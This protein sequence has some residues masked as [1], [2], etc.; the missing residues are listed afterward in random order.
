VPR[1]QQAQT[2]DFVRSVK[3]TQDAVKQL[4]IQAGATVKKTI[5]QVTAS[6]NANPYFW[7]GDTTGWIGNNG[8]LSISS[9]PPT[10]T[11]FPYAGFFTI[12]NAGV[13]AAMEE[14]QLP[15]F[16]VPGQ[17]YTVAAYVNPS[18]NT[19]TL[20]LAWTDGTGTL[21]S[22]SSAT[23][24]VAP[25]TWTLVS[26]TFT[27]PTS[28]VFGY[29]RVAPADVVGNTVYATAITTQLSTQ[30]FMSSTVDT[31][32]AVTLPASGGF[33]GNIRVKLSPIPNF[34]I[35][36]VA[37]RWTQTTAS[38][39]TGGSLPSSAYYPLTARQLAMGV[40][41]TPTSDI[42]AALVIPTSGGIQVS[43]PTSSSG[44]GSA[45]WYGGTYTYPLD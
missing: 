25:N 29:P 43:I 44:S 45:N 6:L 11:P 42:P 12:S 13:G 5:N 35:L 20:N 14:S 16:V 2:F 7:G 8:T 10:P 38:V 24:S 23:L 22:T 31:W 34:A 32:H 37:V 36:D 33:S 1:Y 4:S 26:A 9:N 21:L 18:S 17:Q 3:G 27:A 30:G 19:V 28:S 41:D 40:G 39:Q 15:F